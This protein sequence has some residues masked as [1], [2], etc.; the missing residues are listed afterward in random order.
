M[1]ERAFGDFVQIQALFAPR[2][3]I[4]RKKSNAELRKISAKAHFMLIVYTPW[5]VDSFRS[6]LA[7]YTES[8][9]LIGAP[10]FAVFRIPST[11]SRYSN[12]MYF[13]LEAR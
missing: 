12:S 9:W 6:P 5:H 8:G 7:G 13:Y 3:S 10:W 1:N 11:P 2:C 4:S